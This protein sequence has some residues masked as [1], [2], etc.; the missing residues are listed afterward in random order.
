MK[1]EVSFKVDL[2][3]EQ[4]AVLDIWNIKFALKAVGLEPEDFEIALREKPDFIP[5]VSP[6]TFTGVPR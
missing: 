2:T 6:A 5:A 4:R 3:P 1:F